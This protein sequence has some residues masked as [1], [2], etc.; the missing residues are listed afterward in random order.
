MRPPANKQGNV[1]AQRQLAFL[2]AYGSGVKQ[3]FSES[4]RWCADLHLLGHLWAKPLGHLWATGF[5]S[6]LRRPSFLSRRA[7]S[8]LGQNRRSIRTTS[9][10]AAS[11]NVPPPPTICI[12]SY[13]ANRASLHRTYDLVGGGKRHAPRSEIDRS[14]GVSMVLLA[15]RLCR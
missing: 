2:H 3:D 12:Q 11:E 15:V 9:N 5:R 1:I 7:Q 13:F 10:H 8:P 6:S 4:A 14:V